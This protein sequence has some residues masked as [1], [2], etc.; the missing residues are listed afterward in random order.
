MEI[1]DV[2][3]YDLGAVDDVTLAV[4]DA[5]ALA[6]GRV[7]VSAAS[8]DTPNAVDDGPAPPR[9]NHTAGGAALRR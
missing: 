1:G 7:L 3:R 6:D 2:R 9:Y 5:V 4:T 8:E